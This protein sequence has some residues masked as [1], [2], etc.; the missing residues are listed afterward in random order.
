VFQQ[1]VIFGRPLSDIYII[2][3]GCS[4]SKPWGNINLLTHETKLI[5]ASGFHYIGVK[6]ALFDSFTITNAHVID[7]VI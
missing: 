6:K 2:A 1:G 4:L 3:V 7:D 5:G